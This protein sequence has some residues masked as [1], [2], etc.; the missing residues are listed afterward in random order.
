MGIFRYL[1]HC[2][3]NPFSYAQFAAGNISV[4]FT[5]SEN[6]EASAR[7]KT[8]H[9]RVAFVLVLRRGFGI[10]KA[11]IRVWVES[12]HHTRF[13][14]KHVVV[15]VGDFVYKGCPGSIGEKAL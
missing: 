14:P 3:P 4:G 1:F 11:M 8:G 9:A 7:V 15:T 5:P 13:S 12:R 6:V 2:S 10:R